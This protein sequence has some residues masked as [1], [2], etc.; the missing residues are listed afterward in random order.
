LKRD[1]EARNYLDTALSPVR[2]DEFD[3]LDIFKASDA[4]RAAVERVRDQRGAAAA[5]ALAKAS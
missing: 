5:R 1:P 3:E 4:A 2:D